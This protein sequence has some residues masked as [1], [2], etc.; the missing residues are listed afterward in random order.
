MLGVR[1]AGWTARALTSGRQARRLAWLAFALALVFLSVTL[2]WVWRYRQ[3]VRGESLETALAALDRGDFAPARRLVASYRSVPSQQTQTTLLRGAM[4]LKK[5][6]WYPALDDLERVQGQPMLRLQA[7]TLAG[8]AWYHLGRHVEAQE[9]LQ[10]VVRQAPNSVDA[11]RW[12]AA[13]YYDLGAIH[14]ALVHLQ[15]TAE[16]DPADQ[17]PHRLLGLIYKDYERFSDAVLAY[18][19]SLRRKPDQADAD[20]V[21]LEMATCLMKLRRHRDALNSLAAC[22]DSPEIDVVRAEC[23]YAIGEMAQAKETL[24]RA[25]SRAPDNLDILLLR[26]TI[27]LDEG[28]A[29]RAV[30]ILSRAADLHPHDYMVHFQLAQAHSQADQPKQAEKEQNTAERIRTLRK[31]FAELHQAAWDQPR[32]AQIRL[33]LAE[34]ATE[35]GRP[36]LAD[37]WLKSAAALAPLASKQAGGPKPTPGQSAGK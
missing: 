13:S 16:L 28:N 12:L 37:V 1:L 15:R 29:Q 33:R 30:E 35:L 31:E 26:G 11:H 23:Y 8:Q 4:L 32:N 14:D 2:F 27:I 19:E 25:S 5:G 3:R 10:E 6:H 17:R 20:N 34:L 22:G 9:A 7:L 36:D 21:R 18:E 24:A